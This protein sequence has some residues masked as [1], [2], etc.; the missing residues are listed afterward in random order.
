MI[1]SSYALKLARTKLRSKRGMLAASVIVASLLFAA[2]IAT[3]IVFTG[4][5]KSAQQFIEKAG[6]NSY[7]VK[8]EP[9]IPREKILFSQRLSLAEVHEIKAF[10]KQYY[11]MLRE[12]YAS[13]KLTYNEASEAPA[14]QPAAWADKTL[15]E[16]QRVVVNSS[17]PVIQAMEAQKIEAYAKTATNKLSDLR[18]IGNK[19]G[20]SG[21]YITDMPSMLPQI[22]MM[23]YVQGGKE[24]FGVSVQKGGMFAYDVYIN[25]I[26]NSAYHFS[27]QRLL[28]RY[29]LTTNTSDLKG[30]PVVVSEQEAVSLF[31]KNAGIGKE[32]AAPH[33]K[34]AWLKSVQEKLNGQTY[35]ACYRNT[36]EQTILEKIQRDYTEMKNNEHT[37]GYE[38]P[39]LL[40]DYP[41][42]PCGNIIVK[43]DSR[44]VAEKQADV[45]ADDAQKK[46]GTYIAPRHQL[47][48]FQIVGIKYAQPY[49]DYT[50]GL[51]EYVKSL[52]TAQNTSM[53]LDI[54][55]Q[56]YNTLP[57]HLKAQDIRR[58]HSA[59][60]SRS[61]DANEDFAARVLEFASPEKARAF[62]DNET[63]PSSNTQ[64]GK[65]FLAAPYGSNYLIIDE[66]SKL[67]ARIAAIA[68]PVALGLAAV[69]IWFTV[70]RIMAENRKETAVYRAMGAKRRDI[71][72]IYVV[73]IMLVALRVVLVS[74]IVGI[75]I[76]LAVDCSYGRALTD[77]AA[78]AFGIVDRAPAVRLF[79]VD[80]PLLFVVVAA[81]VVISLVASMQSLVR[82]TMRNPIRDIR[83]E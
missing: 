2:L 64:C 34:R 82:N 10:E 23:R 65:K 31:G 20:A 80:S 46:L 39:H 47:V 69:I 4:A 37:T 6:N 28:S 19:Y 78:T 25:A 54:P 53:T 73:Y 33:E 1:R 8:T 38:K 9:N 83:D 14:L 17:S 50:K 45:N 56:M 70:S 51:D 55:L 3:I 81:I 7:L 49:I 35:Q 61:M 66:I 41:T 29:L 52:L 40:Y 59:R 75:V 71:A 16:E 15:P 30:I 36:A 68:F 76:A 12:K 44:T 79:N 24:N 67:F 32:P 74:V 58:E 77:T 63:C 60:P 21:Y 42:E 13:L 5:E 26:Y 27:D 18:K 43:E 72:H 22:P 11:Q 48:T 62:L 57:E